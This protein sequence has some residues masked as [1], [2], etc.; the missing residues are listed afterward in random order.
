M[1]MHAGVSF[2]GGTRSHPPAEI[3]IAQA[4]RLPGIA[5]IDARVLLEHV[6]D[7]SHGELVAHSERMLSAAEAA[8][9]QALLQRRGRGEP[10]AYLVGRREFYGLEFKVTPDVLIPRPETELLVE[11]ALRRMTPDARL[12]IVDLGTGSG[13]VAIVIAYHRPDARIIAADCSREALK[14]A[15]ENAARLLTSGRRGEAVCFVESNWYGSLAGATFDL[16]V[17]NPP[18]VAAADPYLG[19][20]DLRFEPPVALSAGTDGLAAIRALIMGAARHLAEGGWLIFE[21]G[22]NQQAACASLLE[23]AGFVEVFCARDLAHLP[24]VCGGRYRALSRPGRS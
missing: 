20:G 22:F 23:S 21:H 6:L 13:N 15:E 17:S 7:A 16:I 18:Y 9:F 19:Q 10:V 4:L 5:P 11:L 3:T 12:R 2:V 24:R 1:R 8:R 14:L